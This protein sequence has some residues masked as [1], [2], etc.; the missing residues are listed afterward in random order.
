MIGK[1]THLLCI[2]YAYTYRAA[3]RKSPFSPAAVTAIGVSLEIHDKIQQS[4]QEGEK[5]KHREGIRAAPVATVAGGASLDRA[6]T[7]PKQRLMSEL[8]S[9]LTDTNGCMID[10]SFLFL[11]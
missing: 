8:G 7:D 4:Q 1:R 11:H 9:Y 2:S 5:T 3:G 10:F 6:A